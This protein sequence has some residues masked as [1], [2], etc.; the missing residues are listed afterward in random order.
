MQRKVTLFMVIVS[1]LFV[2]RVSD[3]A[4]YSFELFG[5]TQF[6]IPTPLWIEQDGEED[7]KVDWARYESKAF[8]MFDSPYYAIRIGIW[9][10]DKA[11]E[12]ELVHEK[13]YLENKP[14][15]V[16]HFQISHGYNLLTVN[17]AWRKEHFDWRLGAGIVLTHPETVIRNKQKEGGDNFPDGFFI[18][19]P[20][21]QIAIDKRFYL[22]KKLY[23]ILEGKFTASYAFYVPVAEGHARV[24]NVAIHTLLGIGYYF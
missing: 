11:W 22:W 20:T 14:N 19:G 10:K 5:G 3:A 2:C 6:N 9:G 18:S 17:R 24:P 16:Q 15:E 7:V 1:M 13:L 21:V 23:A 4:E 8:T 12:F